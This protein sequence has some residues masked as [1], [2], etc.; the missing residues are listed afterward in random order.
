ME[1]YLNKTIKEI[2]ADLISGRVD[3]V[4]LVQEAQERI[5][6]DD[7]NAYEAKNFKAALSRAKS[8]HTVEASDYLYGIPYVAKDNYST[9]GVET[10]ASSKILEGYIP[11]FDAE[12][13]RRLNRAGGIMVAKSAMDEFAMGGTGTTGHKGDTLNPWDHTRIVGGSS[14][15]SAVSVA[16]GDVPYALGSDTGDSVRKPASHA[17]LV[18]FKP[19]W[20]LVSRYGLLPF[21]CSLDTVG[22]FTRCVWDS[23][24][25]CKTLAGHDP[26][27]MTSL[28]KA[29][30]DYVG[31][32][33]RKEAGK[34]ICW[35]PQVLSVCAPYIGQAFSELVGK[36]R[37]E[38]YE[39]E[40]YEFPDDL[41]DA[42]YPTYMIISCCESTSNDS[43]YDGMRYGPAGDADA[44]TYQE[45]MTSARTRGFSDLIKR[46]FVIG[47]YSLLAENQHDMFKRAQ[48]A[49]RVIVNKL[50]EMFKDYD[51]LLLPAA[52]RLP[53]KLEAVSAKW[54]KNPD[55]GD[56]HLALANFGGMPSLTVPMGME[57]GVPFGV[58]ITGRIF[59]D[60]KVL[61]LGGVVESLTGLSGLCLDKE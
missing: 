28:R 56:N 17:G 5:E 9:K 49:R 26:K 53:T 43:M 6:K 54:S 40:P 30:K 42:I 25:I 61:A 35:F 2:H 19:T 47:S 31:A 55:F 23:A 8:L 33:E 16:R 7:C 38:G 4:Q 51:Y 39:V 48:K 44:K 41:L 34:K 50:T 58:N 32:V 22:W 27:D 11:L 37:E 36:L 46:R 52:S 57:Q 59:E 24:L 13:I 29:K 18:G 10:T 20:G 14:S 1:K 60:D 45:F 3:P 12:V 21:A 15:G